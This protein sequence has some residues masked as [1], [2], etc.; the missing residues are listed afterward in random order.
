[1]R[2]PLFSALVFLLLSSSFVQAG[3]AKAPRS[4]FAA[5][6][7]QVDTLAKT[8]VLLEFRKHPEKLK[9]GV[10]YIRFALDRY[11][12]MHDLLVVSSKGSQPAVDTATYVLHKVKFPKIP[13][14]VIAE[15]GSDFKGIQAEAIVSL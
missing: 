6:A 7:H 8:A 15:R 1:M 4:H 13:P 14:E 9:G 5:F 11:G 3:A 12:E 10:L 2:F